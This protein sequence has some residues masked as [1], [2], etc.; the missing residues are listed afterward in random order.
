MTTTATSPESAL[1]KVQAIHQGKGF[2]WDKF[3]YTNA[4]SKV[5]VGCPTHGYFDI[6]FDSLRLGRGCKHCGYLTA[7]KHKAYSTEEF[8]SKVKST[9][10]D[11]NGDEFDYSKVSYIDRTTKVTVTCK[12]HGDFEMHPGNAIHSG[13]GCPECGRIL[14]HRE[15]L[16]PIGKLKEDISKVLDPSKYSIEDTEGYSSNRSYIRM[17]CA[18]HGVWETKPNW[19]LSCGRGCPSCSLG[20]TS[21]GEVEM[22]TFIKSLLPAGT[23]VSEGDRTVLSGYELDVYIPEFKIAFEYNGLYWHSE[24]NGKMSDYHLTKTEKC[25]RLGIQLVHIYEDEWNHKNLIVKDKIRHLLG[26]KSQ[27]STLFA[28]ALF[29]DRVSHKEANGFFDANHIQGGM[30]NQKVCYGLFHNAELIAAMSFGNVRF[31]ESKDGEVELLR[32]AVKSGHH[33]PGGFSRLLKGFL[34][35]FEN[36]SIISSFSDKRWSTGDVYRKNGFKFVSSSKPSYDYTNSKGLRYNRQHFM[37]QKLQSLVDK[38]LL[39]SFDPNLTEHQNCS[40][41]GY[42]RVWNCGMDKW[43]LEASALRN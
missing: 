36:V 25:K 16:R 23:K 41:N 2:L 26:V 24:A 30:P 3:S 29:I 17:R 11:I 10:K 37:K 19:I 31:G 27:A 32:Y 18:E 5:T 40:N 42:W 9:L 7:R 21:K 1:L 22:S 35:D 43:S 28:R 34:K 20:G 15:F 38:G 13:S 4:R 6:V 14:A 12:V 33:V 8:V 39:K